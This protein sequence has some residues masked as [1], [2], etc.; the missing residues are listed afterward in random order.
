MAEEIGEWLILKHYVY[1]RAY[2]FNTLACCDLL[3]PRCVIYEKQ[4]EHVSPDMTPKIRTREQL[5]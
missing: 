1:M 3:K 2:A 4:A 5:R